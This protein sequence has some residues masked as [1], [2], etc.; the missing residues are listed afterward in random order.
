MIDSV[1]V[2]KDD[3]KKHFGIAILDG[4]KSPMGDA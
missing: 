1:A 2:T 4:L 3:N